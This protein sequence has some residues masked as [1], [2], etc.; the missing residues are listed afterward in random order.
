MNKTRMDVTFK[1]SAIEPLTLYFPTREEAQKVAFS[2]I[3]FGL[4]LPTEGLYVPPAQILKLEV[5]PPENEPT[6]GDA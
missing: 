6:Q 3:Q 4:A 1:D 5:T 2:V